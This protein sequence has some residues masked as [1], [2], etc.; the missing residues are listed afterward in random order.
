MLSLPLTLTLASLPALVLGQAEGQL[1]GRVSLQLLPLLCR[2]RRRSHPTGL[3]RQQ[4]P[5][6]LRQPPEAGLAAATAA[7]ARR[8]AAAELQLQLHM[9]TLRRPLLLLL[10]L[11]LPLL[12]LMLAAKAAAVMQV[13][14]LVQVQPA[15]MMLRQLMTAKPCHCGVA[16]RPRTHRAQLHPLHPL[17][18]HLQ[19]RRRCQQPL[20][21]MAP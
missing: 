17:L 14:V 12:L 8:R 1:G 9:R 16:G 13:L 20:A 15:A 3:S 5:L 18:P 6:P 4:L 2:R 21:G 11:P 7:R 10:F 19:L